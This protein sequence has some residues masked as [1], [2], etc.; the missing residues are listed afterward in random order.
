MNTKIYFALLTMLV[1]MSCARNPV[2]GKKE[3]SLM[4][5]S[6]EIAMGKDND[7]AIVAQFGLYENPTLQAFITAKGK[8]MAAISHRPN[9]PYEFKIL[10][11]PIVNAFA[12]PGGYVYFTRGIMGHFN[13][14]AEFTGVLGHEIGHITAKHAA[15][16]QRDQIL[17]QIGL[18]G[19]MIFSEQFRKFADV[20]QQGM[21]LLFLKFSRDHE[22]ESDKLGV[23]YSTKIGYDAHQMAGF[24]NTLKKLSGEGGAIPTFL[25]THPDPGDRYNKVNMMATDIQKNMDPA[26]LKINRNNYLRMIDGI[27]HGEDPKQ[28]YAE[29][30]VFYHPELKFQFNIPTAWK[31]VNSPAQIQMA[32]ADGKALMMMDLAQG[33]D[34]NTAKNA[35][36][37]EN[38]LNVLESTNTT[39]NGLPAIAMLSEVVQEAQQGQQASPPLKVLT[40]LIEYNKLIYKF[41]GLSAST[42]FNNYFTNFQAT[43]KSFKVLTDQA[44]INKKPTLIKIVETNKSATLQQIL[45]DYSMPSAKHAELAILNGL[46]L[47]TMVE[48]G[49][50]VK[51]FGGQY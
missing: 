3:L 14:E 19:G 38:K 44:K 34:L 41:H 46:E 18:M 30:N 26:T 49:T 47:N 16:Q 31:L 17:A 33:A 6:Q 42:D 4:S 45:N 40:Y 10:D 1:V 37:Q 13:N 43:M 2:T 21:G 15:R 24:F 28:G 50:L 22:S 25:S 35:V 7:P 51:V 36:I 27:I 29:N 39:V 8:E 5:E 9:L 48:S 32:P 11:S 23:E 20:A 12:V